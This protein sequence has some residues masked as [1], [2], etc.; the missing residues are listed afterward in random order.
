MGLCSSKALRK[1][2]ATSAEL[3]HELGRFQRVLKPMLLLSLNVN[4][5]S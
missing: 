3:I 5:I 1:L 4:H 2:M